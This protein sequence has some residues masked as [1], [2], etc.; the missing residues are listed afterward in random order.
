[1]AFVEGEN[2]SAK[3]KKKLTGHYFHIK[4]PKKR[5]TSSPFLIKK[6]LLFFCGL[7]R[8]FSSFR[9]TRFHIKLFAADLISRR[10]NFFHPNYLLANQHTFVTQSS[11]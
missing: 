4:V 5:N 1:M 11:P 9:Y 2:F 10:L 8:V 6:L 3:A 7:H